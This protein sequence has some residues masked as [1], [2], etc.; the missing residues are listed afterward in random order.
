MYYTYI[1]N[2]NNVCLISGF[3][4]NED[5]LSNGSNTNSSRFSS[6]S[7][8]LQNPPSKNYSNIQSDVQS[9]LKK[10]MASDSNRNRGPPPPAPVRNIS[11]SH[12]TVLFNS[13]ELILSTA[14]YRISSFTEFFNINS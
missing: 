2:T 11:V 1:A 7:T 5:N 6:V 9:A 13:F 4:K 8:Q 14:S 3:V 12:K 10:Q